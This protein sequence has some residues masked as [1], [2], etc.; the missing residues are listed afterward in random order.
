MASGL[1][2]VA[3][4]QAAMKARRDELAVTDK[5]V[6]DLMRAW[7][8]DELPA[9]Q[10]CL[11]KISLCPVGWFSKG[12]RVATSELAAVAA[13]G[14]ASAIKQSGESNRL[15]N[16]LV[17]MRKE[18]SSETQKIETAMC[19]VQSRVDSLSDRVKISRERALALR[20]AGRQQ[21]ALRELKKSKGTEKQLAAARM[22]LDTLE[23]QSD[24]IAE[25]TL[26]R[27]LATALKSTTEG[28][29]KKSKGVLALAE[30][31]IDDATEARDDVQDIAS[32]FEGMQP[33]YG[34]GD[35]DELMEELDAMMEEEGGATAAAA[36]AT[37]PSAAAIAA[38]KVDAVP[39][40]AVAAAFELPSV[41]STRKQEKRALL[42]EDSAAVASGL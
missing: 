33:A 14:T 11:P 3:S 8:P 41:P 19:A 42:A 40:G 32:V 10:G 31:A 22:A 34:D 24:M 15:L 18:Q 29:K 38:P 2:D 26:Q 39:A 7:A 21:E 12:T 28:V 6:D 27:E 25:S 37:A 17:G 36:S 13:P 4:K 9:K 20:Q 5:Q 16:R 30:T 35:D 23:R 1:V